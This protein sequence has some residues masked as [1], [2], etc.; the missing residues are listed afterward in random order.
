MPELYSTIRPASPVDVK[1]RCVSP[2]ATDDIVLPTPDG[3]VP[4]YVAHPEAQPTAGLVVIQEAFGVNDHIRGV[5]NRFAARGYLVAAPSLFHRLERPVLPY[6]EIATAKEILPTLTEA[7]LLNDVG[8][9]VQ[10]LREQPN[11][12][13][14][15]I[16]AVGFC[17]GG[18]VAF[19]AATAGV[20]ETAVCFYGGGIAPP[21]D[22]PVLA[23][24]VTSNTGPVL[25][26][27]G[28]EDPMIDA[29]ERARVERALSAAGPDHQV[30]TYEGAGHGFF[31]DARPANYD[32]SA[33]EQ[34]WPLTLGFLERFLAGV[35]S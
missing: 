17:F 24:R 12:D 2:S 35:R 25:A 4:V 23:D 16:G 19:L 7:M 6:E 8:A 1:E 9:A 31:C 5:A 11:R 15:R 32:A 28:A 18:R 22:G 10:W 33:A 21:T 14:D 30:V 27:Y 26:V 13:S 3:D 29:D 34:A 20:V